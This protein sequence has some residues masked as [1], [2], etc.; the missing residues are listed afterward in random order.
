MKRKVKESGECGESW[1]DLLSLRRRREY[2]SKAKIRGVACE[3]D[4]PKKLKIPNSA[5]TKTEVE[6]KSRGLDT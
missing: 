1:A 5:Y 3:E 6:P 2:R 4:Q